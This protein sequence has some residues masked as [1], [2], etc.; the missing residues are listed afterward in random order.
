MVVARFGVYLVSLDPT[1]G[2]EMSKTRPCVV[3]SPDEANQHLRTAIIAPMTTVRR[4]YPTRVACQFGRKT[5]EI[6]LD[7]IRTVDQ[8]RLTKRLGTLNAK[9]AASVLRTLQE[10]FA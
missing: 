7:Q 5:G 6:A 9:T 1:V 4:Q 10:M 2:T 3:I 8:T